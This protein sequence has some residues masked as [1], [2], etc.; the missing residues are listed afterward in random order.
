MADTT[1]T[2]RLL[3]RPVDMLSFRD[4]RSFGPAQQADSRLPYPQTLAGAIRTY[5]L[6]AHGVN[7]REFGNRVRKYGSFDDALGQ[8]GD[9]VK[10]LRGMQIRGPWLSMDGQLVVP[11]PSNVRTQKSSSGAQESRQ[12]FRLDP[13]RTLP[14]GWQHREPGLRPLWYYGRESLQSVSGYIT[15][16]G[17][18][19]FLEGGGPSEEDIVRK[20]ML[21]SIDRRVGIGIDFKQKTANEGRIYTA[22]M[23]ALKPNVAFCAEVTGTSSLIMPLFQ[24]GVLMKF[25]GEGRYVEVSEHDA[26]LWPDVSHGAGDGHLL[27]LTTPAWFNGWKPDKLQCIAASVSHSDGISGWDFAQGGPKPNRFMVPAGSVYFLPKD[28][29]IPQSLVERHDSLTGWGHYLKGNWNYV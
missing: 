14:P 4:G 18:R 13:K 22:G 24:E 9:P 23:L 1:I 15:M 25:G 10:G 17:L 19:I 27:F 16:R 11:I 2:R 5:L 21:Y 26:P 3:L 12:I 8:Y 20:E 28:A 6:K 7:V 29:H